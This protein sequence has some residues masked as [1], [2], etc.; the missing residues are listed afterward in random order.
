MKHYFLIETSNNEWSSSYKKICDTYEEAIKEVPNFADWYC[1]KGC[2]TVHEVD[3]NFNVCKT[4]KFWKGK[5][6]EVR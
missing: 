5:L 6:A 1:G 3:N 4:Y 2:C